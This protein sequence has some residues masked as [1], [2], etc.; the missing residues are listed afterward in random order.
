MSYTDQEK[1]KI[2]REPADET[3]VGELRNF[4]N[5]LAGHSAANPSKMSIN[6]SSKLE[7]KFCVIDKSSLL[8]LVFI[9]H[10]SILNSFSF[11]PK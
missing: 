6:P 5:C 1:N 11:V 2:A 9:I 10:P 7:V 3:E 8:I 4:R